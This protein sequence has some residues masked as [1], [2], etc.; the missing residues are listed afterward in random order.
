MNSVDLISA[1]VDVSIVADDP[2][3]DT[4]VSVVSTEVPATVSVSTLN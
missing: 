3:E 4:R 2:A 1:F